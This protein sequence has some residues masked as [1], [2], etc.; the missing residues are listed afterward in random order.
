MTQRFERPP[1]AQTAVLAEL[2]RRIV[3][4]ELKP[5]EAIRQEALARELGVSRLPVREALVVLEAEQLVDYTR[6]RGYVASTPDL[7]DLAQIYHL[8]RILEVE[9]VRQALPR[10]T[11]E[12]MEAMSASMAAMKAIEPDDIRRLLKENRDFH[13]ILFSA[14]NNRRLESL[15]RQLWDLCDRSR[16]LYYTKPTDLAR[17]L[18]EHQEILEACSSRDFERTVRILERHR[19][20]G[21]SAMVEIF[22]GRA[23]ASDHHDTDRMPAVGP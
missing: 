12:N 19:Q 4:G 11:D 21:L 9:A 18:D 20:G 10:L 23:A 2:R 16:I 14:S 15:L 6:H 5:G 8:R 3:L 13:F 22:A 1:T 7:E 17:V